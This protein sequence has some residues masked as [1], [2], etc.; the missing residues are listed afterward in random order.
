MNIDNQPV[1]IFESELISKGLTT[2]TPLWSNT[3]GWKR[4]G[5]IPEIGYLFKVA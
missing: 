5:E 1:E 4:A 3:T 2:I